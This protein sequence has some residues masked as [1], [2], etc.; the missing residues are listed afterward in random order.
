MEMLSTF[1]FEDVG[2]GRTK[3]TVNWVPINATD[4]ERE[5]FER[6]AEA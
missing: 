5:T 2:S 6:A 1:L 3:V 4:V